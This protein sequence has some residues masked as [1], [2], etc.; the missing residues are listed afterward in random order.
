[1]EL[2]D[3]DDLQRLIE[4]IGNLSLQKETLEI[5]IMMAEATTIR[6]CTTDPKY[7]SGGKAPT[8]SFLEAT[9]K[10]TGLDGEIVP[11]RY[12]L[13]DVTA[14]LEI[15]RKTYDLTKNRIEVWRSEQA[16]QRSAL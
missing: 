5:D 13:A 7:F 15:L 12:K 3:F 8:M 2:P 1:M 14:R 9:Y 10:Q 11:L 4:N 6:T 16:T